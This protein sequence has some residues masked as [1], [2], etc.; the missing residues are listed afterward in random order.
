MRSPENLLSLFVISLSF[1][2]SLILPIRAQNSPAPDFTLTDIDGNTFTL[3]DYRGNLTVLDF[4]ATWC[5][6]CREE[7][8]H[9]NEVYERFEDE[10]VIVSISIAPYYDADERLQAFREEFNMKWTIA[11]DTANIAINYAV[12]VIP[13]LLIIDKDGDLRHRHIGLTTG[14]QLSKEI[15]QILG[16]TEDGQPLDPLVL[17]AALIG[18]SAFA[19][20]SGL[21]S[22][23]SPCGFALL[24][25]FVSYRFGSKASIK[26][27]FAS[28]VILTLGIL[29]ILSVLGFITATVGSF[30]IRHIPWINVIIAFLIIS[31]G[32]TTLANIQLPSLTVP[33]RFT[34]GKGLTGLYA[35]GIAYGL[36]TSACTAPIF[37]S[38]LIYAAT[39][40]IAKGVLMLSLYTLGM[41]AGFITVSVLTAG[42]RDLM[43][44]RI[45][46]L[47]PKIYK[48]SG[49]AIIVFGIYL[50]CQDLVLYG[51]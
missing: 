34:E 15:A 11:R 1:A 42:A 26:E 28:G 32:F 9:L 37:F 25:A 44:K 50:L 13:T 14:S 7:V 22:L 18:P 24:P 6:P 39:I 51:I 30:I 49:L 20:A 38:I 45:S 16:E 19:L 10:I 48:L 36:G 31:L 40:G 12:T 5:G 23:L 47:T 29:T 17:I 41:G 4:M 2:A 21:F 33:P 8:E 35:F 46:G 27:A 43:L 3:S